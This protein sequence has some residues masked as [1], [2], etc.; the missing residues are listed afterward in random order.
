[1][2]ELECVSVGTLSENQGA[3]N[4]KWSLTDLCGKFGGARKFVCGAVAWF[5]E[6]FSLEAAEKLVKEAIDAYEADQQGW[7]E[8]MSSK[9]R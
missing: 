7:N 9:F 5:A 6:E 3:P 1:M 2:S 8:W 4:D